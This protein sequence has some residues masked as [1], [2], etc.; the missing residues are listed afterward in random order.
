MSRPSPAPEAGTAAVPTSTCDAGV[1]RARAET[2]LNDAIKALKAAVPGSVVAGW[3]ERRVA[4][5]H[6]ALESLTR[7]DA[8]REIAVESSERNAPSAM[9]KLLVDVDADKSPLGNGCSSS[10]TSPATQVWFSPPASFFSP[11]PHDDEGASAWPITAAESRIVPPQPGA[12]PKE[13]GV[14][15]LEERG[16]STP[17]SRKRPAPEPDAGTPAKQ[18]AVRHELGDCKTS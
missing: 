15:A 1:A 16:R 9:P 17:A 7:A 10:L 18:Q 3:I 8:D 6:K 5:A 13:R 2:E 4:N 12:T 11:R 14:A